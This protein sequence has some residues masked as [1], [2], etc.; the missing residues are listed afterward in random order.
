MGK[1]VREESPVDDDP[2]VVPIDELLAELNVKMPAAGFGAYKGALEKEQIQYCHVESKHVDTY[3]IMAK[4][5][6]PSA[7]SLSNR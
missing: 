5:H 1:R 6:Y 3:R 2:I 7:G 4:A